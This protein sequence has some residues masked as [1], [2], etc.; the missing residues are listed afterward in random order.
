MPSYNTWP[1]QEAQRLLNQVKDKDVVVF[2]TGYGPSGLPHIGTFGE[3]ARTTMVM[4]A[5]RH[6]SDIPVKLIVFSDDMDALRKI[7]S[8]IL[9]G[10]MLQEYIG[11]PLTSV[12][13][14]FGTHNSFAE[15]NNAQLCEF[16]DRYGFEYEFR[17]STAEY[18]SGRFNNVLIHI[19]KNVDKIM[20]VILP[21]LGRERQE[22][23]CPFLPILNGRMHMD[24]YAWSINWDDNEN[25]ILLWWD[26]VINQSTPHETPILNGNCKLQWKVDWAMRWMAYGVDYEMHGKDLIESARLGDIFCRRLGF[27]PPSHM[28]YELFLDEFGAKISKSI[29]NGIDIENWWHYGTNEALSYFMFQNPKKARKLYFRVVPQMLDDYI[30]HLN[31][32]QHDCDDYDNPAWHVHNGNVPSV[33][34]PINFSM[35][36]NLVSITNTEDPNVI[37]RYVQ[38]YREDATIEN[39]PLLSN[40]VECAINFYTD[41]ILPEKQY[42]VPTEMERQALSD[43]ALAIETAGDDEER[44]TYEIYESGKRT[45]GK[46]K[47]RDFFQMVYET[48]MG[49]ESGPRLPVFVQLYGYDNTLRLITETVNNGSI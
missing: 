10:N 8:N 15:H 14:P 28:V 6:L 18:R 38:N 19:A 25:P 46:D 20:D 31:E 11:F 37:L 41:F 9:N 43:L 16:L 23:Y 40:L 29:G 13:D 2:E 45:Y 12:P 3:V 17:S 7:P 1:F 48:L 32:F 27:N 24:V 34:C 4:N 30:R 39:Y 33:G 47:L 21:T 22:S 35:L 44:L 26:D 42:R 49:Q 5:F 36:L